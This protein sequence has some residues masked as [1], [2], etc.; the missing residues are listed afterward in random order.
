MR[1]V[2]RWIGVIVILGVLSGCGNGTPAGS[3]ATASG[4]TPLPPPAPTSAS[5]VPTTTAAPAPAPSATA[6]T[7]QITRTGTIAGINQYIV[8]GADGAWTLTDRRRGGTRQGRLT[9]A[10]LTQ[11]RRLLSDPAL[12]AEAATKAPPGVCNDGL[13]SVLTTGSLVVRDD[14]CG[15]GNRPATRAVLGFVANVIPV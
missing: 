6:S 12:A 7:V 4:A 8:I 10:Q 9:A 1:K 14:G 11:L 3:G 15:V 13:A 5:S 2:S